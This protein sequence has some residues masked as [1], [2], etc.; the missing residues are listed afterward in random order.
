[1]QFKSF[2][3]FDDLPFAID[4]FRQDVRWSNAADRRAEFPNIGTVLVCA[5]V[6]L[7]ITHNQVE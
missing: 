7:E 1:M 6:R 2:P 4:Q 5:A 3:R